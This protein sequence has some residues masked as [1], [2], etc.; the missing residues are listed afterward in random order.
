MTNLFIKAIVF[1]G[2][3]LALVA[4]AYIIYLFIK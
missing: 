2:G 3:P 1:G 4:L